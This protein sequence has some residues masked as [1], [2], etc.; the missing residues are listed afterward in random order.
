MLA[1]FLTYFPLGLLL[2]AKM[3]LFPTLRTFSRNK[4]DLVRHKRDGDYLDRKIICYR[5]LLHI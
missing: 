4:T 3:H 5:I 1:F 2:C